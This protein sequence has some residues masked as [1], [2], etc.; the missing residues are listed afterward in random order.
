MEPS[1]AAP[2]ANYIVI[3]CSP[4]RKWKALQIL[5]H[6]K[7]HSHSD[8]TMTQDVVPQYISGYSCRERGSSM[9]GG[10][11]RWVIFLFIFNSFF[12]FFPLNP[13]PDWW[14]TFKDFSSFCTSHR[15]DSDKPGASAYRNFITISIRSLVWSWKH[16]LDHKPSNSNGDGR[17][18]NIIHWSPSRIR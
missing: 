7:Y 16:F 14:L 17:K 10:L 9:P 1:R 3:T 12:I 4:S 13:L 18:L 8:I 6:S 15:L 11:I 5:P 2:S